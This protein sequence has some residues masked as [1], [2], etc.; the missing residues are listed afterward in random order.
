[1]LHRFATVASVCVLA[2]LLGSLPLAQADPPADPPVVPVGNPAP[3]PGFGG[4]C[5][6]GAAPGAASKG[7]GAGSEA[8]N[9]VSVKGGSMTVRPD[10]EAGKNGSV[11][12]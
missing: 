2:P 8:D 12:K 10:N 9:T 6:S 1:M 4:D 11:S 5:C 7:E 3:P